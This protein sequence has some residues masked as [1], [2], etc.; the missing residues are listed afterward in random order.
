MGIGW[1]CLTLLVVRSGLVGLVVQYCK[2]L[3][4]RCGWNGCSDLGWY[5]MNGEEGGQT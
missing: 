4:A 1:C 2:C 5:A 3:L